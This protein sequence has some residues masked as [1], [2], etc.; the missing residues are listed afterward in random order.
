MID[1]LDPDRIS[2][3]LPTRALGRQVLV[4]DSTAS[5]HDIAAAYAGSVKNQGTVILAEQQDQGRGRGGNRWQS[6][7]G[8]S[9]LCSIVLINCPL[10]PNLLSLCTA[11]AV[12]EAIGPQARIKWPNDLLVQGKKVCGILTERRVY[13]D[14]T[15]MLVGM[16]INCHQRDQ[17]FPEEIRTQATSLDRVTGAVTDRTALIRRVLVCLETWLERAHA[18]AQAVVTQWSRL[19][20]LLGRRVTVLYQGTPF[21][22]HCLGI[23]PQDGLILRLDSGAIRMFEAAHSS[24]AKWS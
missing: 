7:R 24:I 13:A 1:P 22:G 11:V 14:H 4:F 20:V 18:D 6:G 2:G 12:A 16:G 10:Q 19:S 8:D 5:T 23:D 9:V 17:D 3:Q 15:A 21:T